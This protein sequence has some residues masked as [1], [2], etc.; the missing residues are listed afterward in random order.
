LRTVVLDA[1]GRVQKIFQGNTWTTD[2][3]VAE[4][5]KA[6]ANSDVKSAEAGKR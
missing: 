5:V 3:M 4:I 2:E 6:S 1:S